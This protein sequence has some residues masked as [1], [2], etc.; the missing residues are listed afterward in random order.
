MEGYIKLL[1]SVIKSLVQ[2]CM[3]RS[4]GQIGVKHLVPAK[5]EQI[6]CTSMSALE[7]RSELK[8]K[9]IYCQV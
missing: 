6:S 3:R 9:F 8:E 7:H 2:V 5:C 1:P 4:I